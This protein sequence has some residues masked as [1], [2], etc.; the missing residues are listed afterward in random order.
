MHVSSLPKESLGRGNREVSMYCRMT[1]DS[2]TEGAGPN[3]YKKNA[4]STHTKQ[5]VSTEKQGN[6]QIRTYFA[7]T[8]KQLEYLTWLIQAIEKVHPSNLPTN[9][10]YQSSTYNKS[11][12][13]CICFCS[14]NFRFDKV[15][16]GATT[17]QL[18]SLFVAQLWKV[19]L[20]NPEEVMWYYQLFNPTIFTKTQKSNSNKTAKTEV[21]F[22]KGNKPS[23]IEG[24]K[25]A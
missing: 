13:F 22:S 10:E 12:S 15:E 2:N 17:F 24:L 3:T 19:C 5:R 14:M 20:K 25:F 23:V 4:S 8:S 21:G 18:Y 6:N 16:K 9:G 1:D 11:T 7:P